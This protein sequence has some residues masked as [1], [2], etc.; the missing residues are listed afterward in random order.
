MVPL[1]LPLTVFL[2]QF[3]IRLASLFL[4]LR[5]FLPPLLLAVAYHLAIL[6]V[7]R[8]FLPV[9]IGAAPALTLRP[10]TDLLLRAINGRQKPTMAVWTTAA[11]L[12]QADSP[13]RFMK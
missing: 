12:A 5:M 4:I 7:G 8:Q 10:A 6:R 1:P 13:Q 2:H 11:K 3:R 9:I